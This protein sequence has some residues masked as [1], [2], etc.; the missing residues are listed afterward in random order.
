MPEEWERPESEGR[1]SKKRGKK[2][3]QGNVFLALFCIELL[4]RHASK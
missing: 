1:M 2:K 4:F 3:S